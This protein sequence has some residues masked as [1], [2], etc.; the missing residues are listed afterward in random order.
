MFAF[1][2][3]Q[4]YTLTSTL[5]AQA[6]QT[7][8]AV[9]TVVN[10]DF[11]TFE[12]GN[13]YSL[14]G[15]VDFTSPVLA[16]ITSNGGLIASNFIGDT[17]VTYLDPSYVGLEPGDTVTIDPANPNQIDWDT[18]AFIPGDSVRVITEAV[19]EPAHLL[20]LGLGS[21]AAFLGL[22]RRLFGS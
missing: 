19:P 9:G 15:Y 17:G 2:E 12:P 8:V 3:V 16:I 4:N 10:S 22:R 14:E 18:A 6:G 11:V 21:L 13:R 5:T 7:T 20:V 1:T